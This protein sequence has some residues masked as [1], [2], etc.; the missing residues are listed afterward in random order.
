MRRDG[1]RR[2]SL[3]LSFRTGVNQKTCGGELSLTDGKDDPD[4]ENV[5]SA[6]PLQALHPTPAYVLSMRSDPTRAL[7]ELPA[8]PSRLLKQNNHKEECLNR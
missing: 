7:H 6:A 3:W 8:S 4:E 2:Q 1:A 5:I